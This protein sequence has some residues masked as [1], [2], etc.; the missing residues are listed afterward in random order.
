MLQ[1]LAL[2]E[3]LTSTSAKSRARIIRTDIATGSRTEMPID[4]GKVLSGKVSD[5]GLQPRDILFV[6]NSTG[7]SALYRSI[8]SAF[9]IGTGLAL[10]RR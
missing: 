6:P 1:A 9:S 4:L 7:R 8:E 5:P 3:G 10:Y 2:A